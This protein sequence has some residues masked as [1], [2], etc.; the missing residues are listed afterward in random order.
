MMITSCIGNVAETKSAQAF[1]KILSNVLTY[2]YNQFQISP[3]ANVVPR[4]MPTINLFQ[5][6]QSANLPCEDVS[7]M[8]VP[9]LR[10]EDNQKYPIL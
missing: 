9:Y 3:L 2:L 5:M 4:T 6:S 10:P 1:I 8:E 7:T